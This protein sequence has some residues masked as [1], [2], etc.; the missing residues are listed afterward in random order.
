MH[1]IVFIFPILSYIAL[2][3]IGIFIAGPAVAQAGP[4]NPSHSGVTIDPETDPEP[5]DPRREIRERI[6]ALLPTSWW[7]NEPESL[8]NTFHILIHIPDDWSGNPVSAI[9]RF[10]PEHNDPI[11]HVL[12]TLELQP[13]HRNR[14]HA[15]VVCRP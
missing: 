7:M 12:D 11:W 4:V 2:S 10:C 8:L 3:A 9:M 1:K 6:G 5:F 13:F 14:H 15:S